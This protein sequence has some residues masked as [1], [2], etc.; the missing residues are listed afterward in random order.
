M[1]FHCKSIGRNISCYDFSSLLSDYGVWKPYASLLD[2]GQSLPLLCYSAGHP[3]SLFGGWKSWGF[4]DSRW[5]SQ[6]YDPRTQT[7]WWYFL[8]PAFLT[9]YWSI[10]WILLNINIIIYGAINFSPS[11][12]KTKVFT[13]PTIVILIIIYLLAVFFS[14]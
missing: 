12:F 13:L 7:A 6:V 1:T 9:R 4:H 2:S 8:I 11:I 3:R 5:L 10:N 14:Y